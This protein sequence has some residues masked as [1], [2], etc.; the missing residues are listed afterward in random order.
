MIFIGSDHAGLDFKNELFDYIKNELNKEIKDMGCYSVESV[1]YPDIAGLVC[2]EVIKNN[3]TG[4]LIC[5]TGIGMSMAAN[6][7]QNIRC[8]LCFD[9]YSARMTRKHN[10][11]N[12]L[13]LGARVIG[14][15][16]A[17]SIADVFLN[18]DFEGGRHQIRIDKINS[19]K[20]S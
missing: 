20:I 7:L 9:E 2:D 13:A 19:M 16:L 18:T 4:I 17:K 15:E 11:A 6:K 1:D 10:N 14:I 12:V 3:G 8:A 5:G